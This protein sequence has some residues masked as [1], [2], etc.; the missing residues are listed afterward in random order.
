MGSG[1]KIAR[2]TSPSSSLEGISPDTGGTYLGNVKWPLK[3]SFTERERA[4][5][6]YFGK[7]WEVPQL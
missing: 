3:L 6:V 7:F 4:V 5:W 1:V 2:A